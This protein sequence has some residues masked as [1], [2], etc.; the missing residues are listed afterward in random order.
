VLIKVEGN[1]VVI[2]PLPKDP[3]AVLERVIGEPYD[4]KK[5]EPKAYEWLK[6]HARS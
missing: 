4:E 2:E 6:K 1:Q 3:Y 5:D